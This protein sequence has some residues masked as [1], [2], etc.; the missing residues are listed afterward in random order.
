MQRKS[1]RIYSFLLRRK[2][3]KEQEGQIRK[4]E[5]DYNKNFYKFAKNACNGTLDTETVKPDFTPEQAF[6]FYSTR[7]SSPGEIDTSKLD[8]FVPVPAP[9]QSY[10]RSAIRPVEVKGILKSKAP[11]TAPGE[12]GLV[13]GVLAKLPSVHHFLATLYTKT[14]E[15]CLAPAAWATSLVILA[16]KAGDTADPG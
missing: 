1:V 4:Q 15:S 6:E 10:N 16:Y 11:N 12:D 14:N 7:Y 8:W 2:N 9:T 13:Y 3:A 5:K